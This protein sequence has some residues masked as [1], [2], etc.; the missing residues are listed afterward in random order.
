MSFPTYADLVG[1]NFDDVDGNGLT[2]RHWM[3][4]VGDLLDAYV[5]DDGSTLAQLH[6]TAYAG[7][8]DPLLDLKDENGNDVVVID[9]SGNVTITPSDPLHNGQ[10]VVQGATGTSDNDTDLFVVKNEFGSNVI[11][12][13]ANGGLRCIEEDV[14]QDGIFFSSHGTQLQLANYGGGYES[15]IVLDDPCPGFAIDAA[16]VARITRWTTLGDFIL[17][18]THAPPLDATLA[19]GECALWFDDTPGAS[20]LKIKAKDSGGTVR[21]GEVALA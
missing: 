12:A 18:G 6:V 7:Q 4:N 9:P 13:T 11:T 14:G 3:G 21:T 2:H 16:A 15:F 5:T 19:A 20:K 8:T 10:F 1:H 17:Q